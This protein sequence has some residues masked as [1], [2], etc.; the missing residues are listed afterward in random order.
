MLVFVLALD[1]VPFGSAPP[2]ARGACLPSAPLGSPAVADR[3]DRRQPSSA[4]PPTINGANAVAPHRA[5]VSQGQRAT[6]QRISSGCPAANTLP[7]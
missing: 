6:F 3:F 2:R 5:H 7:E 4:N 1:L